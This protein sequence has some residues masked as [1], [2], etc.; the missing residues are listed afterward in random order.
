MQIIWL[1]PIY[2]VHTKNDIN[3]NIKPLSAKFK[4]PFP[5]QNH[6]KQMCFGLGFEFINIFGWYMSNERHYYPFSA[7]KYTL[8]TSKAHLKIPSK[9]N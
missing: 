1:W 5:L 2:Y 6:K 3:K 7:L 4:I 9:Y 8:S